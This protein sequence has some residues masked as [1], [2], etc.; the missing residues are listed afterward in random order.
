MRD[1]LVIPT[2]AALLAFNS[3][4]LGCSGKGSGG[5]FGNEAGTGS[6]SETGTDSEADADS[7]TDVLDWVVLDGGVYDMGSP[8]GVGDTDERPRHTVEIRTFRMWRTEVTVGQYDACVQAGVC[9]STPIQDFC[10]PTTPDHL[11]APRDC[12]DWNQAAAFC[13]WVE[14]RLP[15][16]AE[17]EFAARSRGRDIAFPW[18]NEPVTCERA[19]VDQGGLGCGKGDHWPVCSKPFGNSAQ[20]L[21]DLAGNV[22]EWVEDTYH[23]SYD[24][25]PD[26]GSAWVDPGAEFRV[27]RGGGIGS[28]G[29]TFRASDRM[30][31]DPGFEYGGLGFRCAR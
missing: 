8:D 24:G 15:S 1:N 22:W 26:D 2:L 9:T 18:G 7:G 16:E 27:L 12:V 28:P 20:G 25:A 5:D 14:G 23:E 29:C 13:H 3:G 19:V 11:D 17:W 4:C 31:H 30:F 6:D 10:D 21:C